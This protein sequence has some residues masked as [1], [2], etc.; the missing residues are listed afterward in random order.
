MRSQPQTHTPA[1]EVGDCYCMMT[2]HRAQPRGSPHGPTHHKIAIQISLCR[3][4]R[5]DDDATTKLA[6]SIDSQCGRSHSGSPSDREDHASHVHI[7]KEFVNLLTP[8]LQDMIVKA[9][10]SGLQLLQHKVQAQ[11]SCITEV[12][13]RISTLGDEQAHAVA[14]QH[15]TENINY[16]FLDRVED[17]E[18]RSRR[19][20]LHF[21]GLPETYLP[22]LLLTLCEK[23]ISKA[24]GHRHS[25]TVERAQWMGPPIPDRNAP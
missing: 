7:A 1:S 22:T 19:S 4:P 25:Y 11:A 17:L 23:V 2:L 6:L 21:V 18:N 15:K 20:I 16:M 14:L 3:L 5:I 13:N 8:T 9:V 24:L 12:E 10:T